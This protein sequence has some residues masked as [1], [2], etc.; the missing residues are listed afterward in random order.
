MAQADPTLLPLIWRHYDA[1]LFHDTKLADQLYYIAR[2]WNR[3]DPKT[4]SPPRYSLADLVSRH[5]GETLEGKSGPDV[6]RLRYHELDNV[7]LSDWPRAAIEYARMDAL[8][9]WRVWQQLDKRGLPANLDDQVRSAWS[10]HLISCWGLRTDPVAVA[11]LRTELEATV[12]AARVELEGAGLLRPGGSKDMAQVRARVAAAYKNPVLTDK[13]AISTAREIL[14]ESGD[15]ALELLAS[16]GYDQKMLSTYIP[17]LESGTT[18]PLMPGYGLAES[19]RTTCRKPNIQNQP[20]K[21]GVRE[22]YV[23]REG[24]VYVACD[25][26]VAELC[27]LAQVCIDKFGHSRMAD[28]LNEGKDLHLETASMILGITYEECSR[29]RGDED[30]KEARQLSKSMNFGLP[31]GLSAATWVRFAKATYGIEVSPVRAQGLKDGWLARYPEMASYFSMISDAMGLQG[32]F[33]ARQV[34]SGRIRGG[35]GFCDGANTYFQGLT[36][37]GARAATYLVVKATH[38]KGDPLEGSHAVAFIHDELIL[39]SPADRAPQAAERLS[40][41]MV[42]GM[43]AY[44][45]DLLV[46][47][48]PHLMERWFKD[49]EP[50]FDQDGVLVPW[51]PNG[52]S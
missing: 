8:S 35:L 30:V 47:A 10:L 39:E 34:R 48:T 40:E 52:L 33:A 7:P 18:R 22:C 26:H 25:Y 31:G 43:Q 12:D 38:T 14:E 15:P 4:G 20:R 36:A 11:R 21:G 51:R 50:V 5:L 17:T 9:T 6:W 28:V 1:G 2:G 23:P 19:G 45:P 29:R 37:D 24:Y 27:S 41:L 32:S 46:R 13:G 3:R 16:V 42:E 49:A 44:L